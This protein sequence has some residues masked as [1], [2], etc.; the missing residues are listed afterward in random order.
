MFHENNN[1]A[2]DLHQ[3]KWNVHI[4]RRTCQDNLISHLNSFPTHTILS[5]LKTEKLIIDYFT[6]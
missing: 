4:T 6:S 1:N 2:W 3:S 5:C